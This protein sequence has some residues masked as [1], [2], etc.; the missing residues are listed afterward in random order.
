M[1]EDRANSLQSHSVMGPCC[2]RLSCR[3]LLLGLGSLLLA[4]GSLAA[5]DASGAVIPVEL[6]RAGKNCGTSALLEHEQRECIVD[7]VIGRNDA[8]AYTFVVDNNGP[9]FTMLITLRTLDGVA[10][11]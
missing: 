3:L 11:M 5:V 2:C 7:D 8:M 9:P 1:E 4:Q 6:A 10:S